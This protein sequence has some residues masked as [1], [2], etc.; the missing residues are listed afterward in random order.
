VRF[1]IDENLPSETADVFRDAGHDAE[2]VL[3]ER[4]GGAPDPVID[5]TCRRENRV[6][7]TLDLDFSDIRGYPPSASPGRIILRTRDQDKM[8]LLRLARQACAA[9][10]AESPRHRPWI[11]EEDRIRIRE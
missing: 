7:V 2:S 10:Q 8:S 9:L 4:L 3:D 1:K 11:V 6:L 5:E